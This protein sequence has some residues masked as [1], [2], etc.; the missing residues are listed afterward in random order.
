MAPAKWKF[1]IQ[2]SKF[3]AQSAI[4]AAMSLETSVKLEAPH[5]PTR[6][7][8]RPPRQRKAAAWLHFKNSI[9][10]AR[11]ASQ[12][13]LVWILPKGGRAKS[14]TIFWKME[15][16]PEVFETPT[17]AGSTA[18]YLLQINSV[19]R[20]R[21]KNTTRLKMLH[22]QP[23]FVPS[24][25]IWWHSFFNQLPKQLFDQLINWLTNKTER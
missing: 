16:R 23:K 18:H 24:I 25:N 15:R 13:S 9:K 19:V 8:Q 10:T 22:Y 12:F 4:E 2:I 21:L 17:T 6:S 20:Q 5:P 11:G 1:E 14:S 7:P 3:K